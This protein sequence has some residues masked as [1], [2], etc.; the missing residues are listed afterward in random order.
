MSPEI[1]TISGQIKSRLIYTDYFENF[2][3][4]AIINLPKNPKP[5][6]RSGYLTIRRKSDG[7]ILWVAE[8]G[9]CPQI[10]A[11]KYFEFSVEKGERLFHH[12]KH[13]SSWQSR[14]SEKGRWGGA[15]VANE[16]IISFSGLPELLDEA[17]VLA[18]AIFLRW[19]SP[20]QVEKI[21]K[22]SSNSHYASLKNSAH[23]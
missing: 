2:I 17:A 10:K 16:L 4:P 9:D 21:A 5:H 6:K 11:K 20:E 23:I 18:F 12:P 1:L 3:I 8:I 7:R 15:I 13:I 19:I 14:D 22:I